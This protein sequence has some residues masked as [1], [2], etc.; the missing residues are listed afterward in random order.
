VR[1]RPRAWHIRR[2]QPRAQFVQLAGTIPQEAFEGEAGQ[3]P[4]S[5]HPPPQRRQRR[6]TDRPM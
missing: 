2:F 6:R 4:V 3:L 5:H 1:S